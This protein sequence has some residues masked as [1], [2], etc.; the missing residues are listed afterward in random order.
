MFK[1]STT[2]M[3]KHLVVENSGAQIELII[4]FQLLQTLL[5]VKTRTLLSVNHVIK[6]YLYKGVIEK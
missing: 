6:G 1:K 2:V 3:G 5:A 4:L